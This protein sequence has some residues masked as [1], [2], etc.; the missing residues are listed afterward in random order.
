MAKK[1]I[2]I[3]AGP[4]GYAAAIRATQLGAQAT[5]VEKGMLGGT[6]LN[7]GCVPTKT[8]LHAAHIYR[9]AQST[10]QFGI[11]ATVDS[12]R[13]DKM[14]A[15]KNAVVRTNVHGIERLFKKNNIQTA[16]GTGRLL[17]TNT[18]EIQTVDGN[19]AQE[20]ADAIIVATGSEPLVPDFIKLDKDRIITTT[21]ALD[22]DRVPKS[23]AII[24]GSVS[25]CE[26][27]SLFAQLGSK[28]YLIEMLDRLIS[29]EDVEISKRLEDALKSLG[30]TVMTKTTVKKLERQYPSGAV[31]VITENN[32]ISA[33]YCLLTMGRK[34]NTKNLN[35][36]HVGIEFS[37]KGIVV[38][39][40]METN[41]NNV[42]AIG[43]VTGK[44]LLAHVAS[45]QGIVAVENIMG[46]ETT[47][48]YAAVPSFIYTDPEIAGVGLKEAEA[49]KQ[50]IDVLEGKTTFKTNAMAH[51]FGETN[52]FIKT[53]VDR[54]TRKILG[55]HM[56]GSHATD[57]LG[58]AVTIVSTGMTIEDVKRVI[59]PHPTFCET[60]KEAVLTSV[61]ESL[62][63]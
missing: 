42:Y 9:I 31:R 43:D 40:K 52:G 13:F 15:R 21:E 62:H 46:H 60:L 50:G 10:R 25:G 58:E 27:A 34:L 41:V 29:M 32:Q 20:K 16:K 18:V 37:G 5:V 35:L 54:A 11:Y 19:T 7:W 33:D 49:N 24:G 53:V 57:L 14:V 2:I 48:D 47:M 26:F 12:F 28:V 45:Q 1:I 39:E 55:I 3:G 6:C 56:L 51:A 36:E 38:N 17:G 4:G 22:L 61:N 59:H 30:V 44:F 63:G 23:V 8:L